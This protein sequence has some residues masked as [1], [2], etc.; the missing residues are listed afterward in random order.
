MTPV[1]SGSPPAPVNADCSV[2]A[3]SRLKHQVRQEIKLPLIGAAIKI[4]TTVIG[5]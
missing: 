2:R 5:G 3:F 4:A 1:F